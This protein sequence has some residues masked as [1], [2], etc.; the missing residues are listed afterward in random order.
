M[1]ET[2]LQA[3]LTAL[4]EQCQRQEVAIR[5]YTDRYLELQES[6][7]AALEANKQLRLALDR[8]IEEMR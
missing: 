4:R 6:Y 1:N 8:A 7:R 5:H 2:E 3:E